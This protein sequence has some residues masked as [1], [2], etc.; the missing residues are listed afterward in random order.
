MIT[1]FAF[2]Q[3]LLLALNGDGGSVVDTIMWYASAKL[4]WIPLYIGILWMVWRQFGV[5]KALI[6][7][8]VVALMILLVD[9]TATFCK[10]EFPKFRP[11]HYPPLEGL[12]HT[13]RDYQGGL[14]GT[15]SSHAANTT[16][17]ALLTSL[18]LRRRWVTWTL[19]AWVV[20]V[21]YSRLYLGVHYP[22]DLMFGFIDGL[23]WGAL[24]WILYKKIALNNSNLSKK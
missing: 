2:D 13:V 19:I 14:Y 24:C 5:R 3:N 4:T 18:T 17:L 6:F 15:V 10:N 21:S 23:I 22:M 7:L 20:L 11:T 12:I 9:Q 16:A 1:P 8:G